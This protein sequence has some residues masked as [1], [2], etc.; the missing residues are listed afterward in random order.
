MIEIGEA[1]V[2]YDQ[3][4]EDLKKPFDDEYESKDFDASIITIP[5][6]IYERITGIREKNK[7]ELNL[8][9]YESERDKFNPDYFI[10]QSIEFNR[11]FFFEFKLYDLLIVSYG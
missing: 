11:C 4:E 9:N 6:E 1:H 7:K 10:E 3:F 5:L 8:Y 2:D